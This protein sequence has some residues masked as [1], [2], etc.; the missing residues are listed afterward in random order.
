VN[1]QGINPCRFDG[2]SEYEQRFV[3]VLL[4]D[5]NATFDCNGQ[6]DRGLHC[7]DA[8]GYKR[9]LRHKASAKPSFLNTVGWA[10]DV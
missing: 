8:V 4:V 2:S 1:N 5:A 3:R 10:A 7:G 9:R 6:R